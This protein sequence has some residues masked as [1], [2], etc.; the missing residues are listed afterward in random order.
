MGWQNFIKGGGR[1]HLV[2]SAKEFEEYSDYL[3]TR[4]SPATAANRVSGLIIALRVSGASVDEATA[5]LML[6]YLRRRATLALNARREQCPDEEIEPEALFHLGVAMIEM[7]ASIP[8]TNKKFASVMFRDGLLIAWMSVVPARRFNFV[9]MK[10]DDLHSD[11]KR[12]F[13]IAEHQKVAGHDPELIYLPEALEGAMKEYLEF[14]RL[15]LLN[16]KEDHGMLWVTYRG[17]KLGGPAMSLA[18]AR[19]TAAHGKAV[20]PHALRHSVG[21]ATGNAEHAAELLGNTPA[22]VRRN[23]RKRDR[24]AAMAVNFAK[25]DQLLKQAA[26]QGES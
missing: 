19:R 22:I 9:D 11:G 24:A 25:L 26:E 1:N 14:Y 21:Q 23:Y 7:A 12:T 4:V 10:V 18:F 8:L 16:K 3:K 15:P 6:G 17:K 5:K 20:R 2:C 13:V